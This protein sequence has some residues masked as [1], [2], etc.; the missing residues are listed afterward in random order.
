MPQTENANPRV[1]GSVFVFILFSYDILITHFNIFVLYL[2]GTECYQYA[3]DLLTNK[4]FFC[5]FW[6]SLSQQWNVHHV[7]FN[8]RI[9]NFDQTENANP[10]VR[11]SAFVFILFSYD[12]LITHFNIFVLYLNG[13]E[14]YQYAFDLLTNKKFFCTFC[15]SFLLSKWWYY[16]IL[17]CLVK[18]TNQPN[19]DLILGEPSMD[20]PVI[21]W[22][23]SLLHIITCRI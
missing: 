4:K 11:G 20:N 23:L 16:I 18:P 9:L 21:W 22:H 13:T 19:W 12:I 17:S 3:F 5:T 1:R 2:N 8:S 7:K 6:L 10:R 14:C 15:F